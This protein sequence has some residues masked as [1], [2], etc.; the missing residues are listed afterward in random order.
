MCFGKHRWRRSAFKCTLSVIGLV[1]FTVQLSYKFY[2]F[3]SIPV[4]QLTHDSISYAANLKSHPATPNYHSYVHLLLDKRYDY[5]HTYTLI[6]PQFQ[7]QHFREKS[8]KLFDIFPAAAIS[9]THP[10]AL[11]RGPPAIS[12]S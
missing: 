1:L 8:I 12:V 4:I 3:A 10:A 6:T 7:V 11:F 5:K 9:T 2:L